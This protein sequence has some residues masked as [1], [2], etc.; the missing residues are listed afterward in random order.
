MPD[1]KRKDTMLDDT[2]GNFHGLFAECQ[3]IW[4]KVWLNRMMIGSNPMARV[5]MVTG[6]GTARGNNVAHCNIKRKRTFK[7]NVRWKKIWVE[8]ENRFV[9]V[10]L[11]SRGLRNLEKM[12]VD[13]G[14]A[15]L[16]QLGEIK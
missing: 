4:Y 10:K 9:R 3:R 2:I 11:S 14:V 15:M 8:S 1:A 12:G 16:R 5:C 13:A 7:T 6:K